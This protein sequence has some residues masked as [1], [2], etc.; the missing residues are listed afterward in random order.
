MVDYDTA[1][2]V[3][4]DRKMVLRTK[5]YWIID[6]ET[7]EVKGLAH[8]GCRDKMNYKTV[9]FRL[10][11]PEKRWLPGGPVVGPPSRELIAFALPSS[12]P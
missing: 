10:T 5:P 3:I 12:L 11:E 6:P 7:L 1:V 4:C 9:A 2:C 8:K